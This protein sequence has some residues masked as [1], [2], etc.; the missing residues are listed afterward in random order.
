MAEAEAVAAVVEAAAVIA[1]AAVAVIAVAAVAVDM[2]AEEEGAGHMAQDLVPAV[3]RM[4]AARMKMSETAPDVSPK[5]RHKR[6]HSAIPHIIRLSRSVLPT[7]L[8]I[9]GRILIAAAQEKRGFPK[10]RCA[11]SLTKGVAV[12]RVPRIPAGIQ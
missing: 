5:I 4:P 7:T 10:L 8:R 9:L 2:A 1:E 12:W 6:T 3:P 11:T